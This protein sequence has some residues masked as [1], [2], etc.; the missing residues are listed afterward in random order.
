MVT[1]RDTYLLVKVVGN[2]FGC[3]GSQGLADVLRLVVDSVI[4]MELLLEVLAL[5]RAPGDP[6]D[7]GPLNEREPS[8]MSVLLSTGCQKGRGAPPSGYGYEVQGVDPPRPLRSE[9]SALGR[10]SP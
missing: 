3:D 4:K 10:K 6:N 7:L 9:N 2:P 8:K 1:G 5:L